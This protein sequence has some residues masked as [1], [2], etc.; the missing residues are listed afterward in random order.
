MKI[1]HYF[2]NILFLQSLL[3]GFSQQTPGN[4]QQNTISI[5]G[6]TAHLGNGKILENSLLEVS[7]FR[8]SPVS[9]YTVISDFF[10]R[11]I[12]APVLDLAMFIHAFSTDLIFIPEGEIKLPGNILSRE[13]RLPL[14]Y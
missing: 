3:I 12:S 2:L 7:A 10:A 9:A 1:K 8:T 5:V 11:T 4:L 13:N 14:K 6:A